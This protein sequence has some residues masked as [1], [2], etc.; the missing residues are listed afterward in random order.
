MYIIIMNIVTAKKYSYPK[1]VQYTALLGS[2]RLGIHMRRFSDQPLNIVPVDLPISV[3]IQTSYGFF[4]DL[5]RKI[6]C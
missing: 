6:R 4:Y 5:L 3:L 2:N 1:L